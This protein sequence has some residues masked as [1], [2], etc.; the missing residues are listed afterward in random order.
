MLR[1]DHTKLICD[2]SELAGLFHDTAS[3]DDLLQRIT[4]VVTEHMT[5]EVCSAYLYYD[6]LN[7]LILK[8]TKGLNSSS[9]GQVKMRRRGFNGQE[10]RPICEGH[11]LLPINK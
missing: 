4:S 10:Q 5:C 1:K 11:I 3:M 8:A 9:I 2:V 6:D 7:E